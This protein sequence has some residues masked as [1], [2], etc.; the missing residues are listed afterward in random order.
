MPYTW[1]LQDAKAKFSE[2]VRRATAE[3]P[4]VVTFRGV[5]TVVVLSMEDYHRLEAG[6]PS[7]ADYLLAGP[8]LEDEA[9]A[10]INERSADTGQELDL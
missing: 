5:E 4:Q 2:V 7:L 10:A 3:G 9:V 8:Q 1:Q 6:C